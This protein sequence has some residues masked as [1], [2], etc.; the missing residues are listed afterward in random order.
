MA[1]FIEEYRGYITTIEGP[2]IDDTVLDEIQSKILV[3]Q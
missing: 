2:R 1:E 3:V